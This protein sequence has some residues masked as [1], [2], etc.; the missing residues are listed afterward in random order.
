[1]ILNTLHLN[2]HP[3]TKFGIPTSNNIGEMLWSQLFKKIG[4]GHSDQNGMTLCHPNM[5]PHTKFGIPTSN[6][7]GD[8]LWT[9]LYSKWGQRFKVTVTQKW[10]E[11]LSHPMMHTPK[12]GFL[13]LKGWRYAQLEHNNSSKLGQRSR[14]TRSQWP[15][16][17][18]RHIIIP[19]C[20]HTTHF[21]ILPQKYALDIIILE[22]RSRSQRWYVT[23]WPKNGMWHSAFPRCI[24]TPKMGFLLQKCNRYA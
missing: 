8:I 2:I 4:Q 21:G 10:N 18:T 20:I 9:Q 13:P 17:G 23:K 15:Q 7:V 11:T 1:M 24:H 16:N 6:N 12:I 19:R 22:I 3:L 5:Y 14:S